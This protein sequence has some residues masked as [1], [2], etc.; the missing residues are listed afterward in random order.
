MKLSD[1]QKQAIRKI[2]ALYDTDSERRKENITEFFRL[3][4]NFEILKRVKTW[5]NNVSGAS[6]TPVGK[7]LAYANAQKYFPGLPEFY[8]E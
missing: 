4:D 3:L 6:I 1:E 5:L 2:Y 7:S 8:S